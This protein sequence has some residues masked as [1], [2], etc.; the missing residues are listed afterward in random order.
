MMP[1]TNSSTNRT[2][3]WI[4]IVIALAGIFFGISA[5]AFL[6][7]FH[8]LPQ[9]NSLKQFK[10]SSASR[11]Y[12]S[13]NQIIDK[14]YIEKR[15]PV[16]IEKIPDVLIT[17]LITTEDRNFYSHFGVDTKSISRALITDILAGR[18][19]QGGSTLTQQLAKTLFLTPEKSIIRKIKEAILTLQIERRYTKDEILELYLNLIFFGSGAYGVEAASRTYFGKHIEDISLGQAAMLAGLPKAPSRYSPFKNPDLAERRKKIVLKQMLGLKKIN[20]N[21]YEEA[22][23]ERFVRPENKNNSRIAPYFIDYIKSSIQ[24]QFSLNKLYTKGLHIYTTLDSSF[25]TTAQESV[26]KHLVQLEKRMTQNGIKHPYPQAALIAIDIKTGGILS[27]I[28]GRDYSTSKYNRAVSAKRQPGSAFKPFVYAC[29]LETGYNQNTLIL[30]ASLNYKLGNKKVWSVQNFS[31]T[32]SGEITWR[33]AL[34]LSKN[35]P[36]VRLID[37][38]KPNRVIEFA[39][40]AGIQSGLKP[41]L[42]LALGTSEV[43]LIEISAAYGVFPNLGVYTKPFG[44]HKVTDANHNT[45]YIN[46]PEKKPVMSRINAAIVTDMLKGV[47]TEGT[48]RKASFIKKEIAG[49]TGTTDNYKDALFIG[50]S[51]DIV[52]GVWVGNDNSTTLGRFETGAKAALPIWIDFISEYLKEKS[53][54]YFDIP[55]GTKMVYIDP[56]RG[57]LIDKR[58]QLAVKVLLKTRG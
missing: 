18:F 46:I 6:S 3:Y 9:I 36:A 38:I 12:S 19:K 47:I 21:Q 37:Q 10:P 7:L 54:Q 20:R 25:Q 24:Q 43:T 29:A 53:Y 2:K 31:N 4:I 11:V 1:F 14:F 30:D 13:D 22:I 17:A 8:D 55:D 41:N 58:N 49:K 26:E 27:M 15:F 39:Q 56:D 23:S 45:L 40:R 44:V 57:D 32:F 52:V 34:A 35:T 50:F 48:G 42:S 51:P 28:G 16:S 5:G 33:K